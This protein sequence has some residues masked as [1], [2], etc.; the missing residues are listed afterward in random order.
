[1]IGGCWNEAKIHTALTH[2]TGVCGTCGAERVRGRLLRPGCAT[3]A[4]LWRGRLRA[5]AGIRLGRRILGL[6][7]RKLGL[8]PG[9][10]GAPTK[11]SCRLGPGALGTDPSRLSDGPGPLAIGNPRQ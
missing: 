1:M 11:V 5:R 7:W 2:H 9:T 3:S 10:L 8:D 6:A 4:A